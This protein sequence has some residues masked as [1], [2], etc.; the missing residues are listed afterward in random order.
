MILPF[1]ER[2]PPAPP[3]LGWRVEGWRGPDMLGQQVCVLAH[4][5]A[6]SLDLDDNSMVQKAVEQRGSDDG[7]AEDITLFGEAAVGG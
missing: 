5:V 4:A 6:G 1:L 2:W 7:I 3:L